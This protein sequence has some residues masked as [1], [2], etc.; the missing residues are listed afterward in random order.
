MRGLLTLLCLLMSG[1]IAAQCSNFDSQW[2][3]STQSINCGQTQNISNCLYGGEYAVCNVVS[4]NTYTWFT[5]GDL[6]FDTQLTVSDQPNG[7]GIVLAYNDDDCGLQSSVTWVATFT[8]TVFVLVSEFN[9]ASNTTCMRLIWTRDCTVLPP[10]NDLICSAE[11]ISC[12]TTVNGTTSGATNVGTGETTACGVTQTTPGVWY[13]IIGTG[14][15]ILASLCNSAWDSKI[16]LYEGTDCINI[17]CI[18]GVDDNGPGCAGLSASIEWTSVIGT[19]YYIKVHGYSTTSDFELTV[20]CCSSDNDGALTASITET[21][22]NDG[23]IFSA[24]GNTG[25]IIAY[26]YSYDN[27]STVSGTNLITV[28]PFDH[29]LETDQPVVYF[30]GVTSTAG[31]PN[32]FTDIETVNVTCAPVFT[33]GAFEDDRITRVQIEN[34]DNSS[35]AETIPGDSYQDFTNLLIDALPG[36]TY[37]ITIEGTSNFGASQ[38]YAV[39]ID[40]DENDSFD[41]VDE[42]IFNTGPQNSVNEFITIP[43]EVTPGLK[44]MRIICAWNQTPSAEPCLENYIYG[45]IEEYTLQVFGP[46]PTELSHFSGSCNSGEARIEW[47]VDSEY[48]VSHYE[49]YGSKNGEQWELLGEKPSLGETSISINYVIEVLAADWGYYRLSTVNF[50]GTIEE[51]DVIALT[52]ENENQEMVIYPNPV[53]DRCKLILP[54][55]ATNGSLEV[56]NMMGKLIFSESFDDVFEYELD[57]SDIPSGQYMILVR[58]LGAVHKKAFCKL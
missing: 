47:L 52:C 51:S 10:P 36:E 42:F 15:N 7:G 9:C 5:C 46:L 43:N 26:E 41:G 53:K 29:V 49:L 56:R 27:F 17:T 45:E 18:G 44:T 34:I 19:I 40:W 28:L 35:S 1:A 24:Q 32:R 25:S 16:S 58:T 11:V 55:D 13:A 38:G 48:N 2:P 33:I 57:L 14:E 31:C 8:G 22:N 21:V 39:W 12:N 23:I 3:N 54:H 4:G 37:P 50:D 6:D 20:N 30:R